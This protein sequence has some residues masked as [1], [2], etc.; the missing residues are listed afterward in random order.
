MLLERARGRRPA[1]DRQRA[2]A[3]SVEPHDPCRPQDEGISCP[4]TWVSSAW[5]PREQG[6]LGARSA[7]GNATTTLQHGPGRHGCTTPSSRRSRSAHAT[8][9]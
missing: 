2:S 1:M 4:P 9:T 5:P 6:A 7:Q 3:R 8:W